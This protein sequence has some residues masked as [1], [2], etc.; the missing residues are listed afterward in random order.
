MAHAPLKS[1][2][3]EAVSEG[4][5]SNQDI[6]KEGAIDMSNYEIV[7][8]QDRFPASARGRNGEFS[9][10]R[11]TVMT[12]RRAWFSSDGEPDPQLVIELESSRT[13]YEPPARAQLSIDDARRVRDALTQQIENA[14]QS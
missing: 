1:S 5:A 12:S 2:P 9:L 14:E 10:A 3:L 13:G 7:P 6:G 4:R 11:V 8:I